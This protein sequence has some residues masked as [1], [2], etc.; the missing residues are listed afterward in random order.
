MEVWSLPL[1]GP[2]SPVDAFLKYWETVCRC[3]LNTSCSKLQPFRLRTSGLLGP[4]SSASLC[5]SPVHLQVSQYF[6]NA[7]TGLCSGLEE[8]GSKGPL[9]ASKKLWG[10]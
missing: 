9:F 7:S 3:I 10:L 1:R 6:R 2:P 4:S 8:A 5:D